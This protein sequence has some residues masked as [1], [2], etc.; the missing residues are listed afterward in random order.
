MGVVLSLNKKKTATGRDGW[1]AKG[2]FHLGGGTM[3]IVKIHVGSVQ[4]NKEASSPFV[5]HRTDVMPH[6][7]ED[8]VKMI[9]GLN[10]NGT[11]ASQVDRVIDYNSTVDDKKIEATPVAETVEAHADP[12]ALI[13][14]SQTFPTASSPSMLMLSP[15]TRVT[16]TMHSSQFLSSTV[17]N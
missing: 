8:L 15:S 10:G 2:R 3:K 12:T 1:Y 16:S 6:S 9:F 11:I 4:L 7:E 5:N 14:Q 17:G 13:Q